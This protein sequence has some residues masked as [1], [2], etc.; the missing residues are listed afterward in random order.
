MGGGGKVH[1][2]WGRLVKKTPLPPFPSLISRRVLFVM[3]PQ[4]DISG[5][6]RQIAKSMFSVHEAH[7]QASGKDQVS[8]LQQF[9]HS[10]FD[11]KR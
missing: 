6:L 8:V 10:Y 11:T 2:D 4:T 7:R 3:A 1:F 5:F 9:R